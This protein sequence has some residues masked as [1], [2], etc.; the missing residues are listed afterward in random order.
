VV[1]LKRRGFDD[2]TVRTLKRAYRMLFHGGGGRSSALAATR[3]AFADSSEVLR[4]VAF[5]ETSERGVC[6]P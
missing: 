2:A 4:L 5:V 1:G 6:R 3:A